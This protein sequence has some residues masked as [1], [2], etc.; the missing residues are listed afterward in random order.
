M[1]TVDAGYPETTTRTATFTRLEPWP[2]A[3]A[4]SSTAPGLAV[5]GH[6]GAWEA[7]PDWSR[8]TPSLTATSATVAIPPALPEE[9]IGA[10][11]EGWLEAPARGVYRF[12]LTSD[13]GSRLMIDDH[14]V[15]DHD[16]LHGASAVWADA[17]L[18]AGRHRLR[19]EYFQH[20]GGR[21]LK[22]EWSGP[23]LARQPVPAS[24]LSH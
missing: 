23:G 7:L 1:A 16:G 11:L 2:A 18:A 24:A 14:V 22:L 15:V 19:V 17:P 12:W 4:A 5:R 3:D 20:L 8:L 6:E 13:D 21:D 9:D 10:V